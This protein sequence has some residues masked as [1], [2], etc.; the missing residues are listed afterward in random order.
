M[1]RFKSLA[2]TATPFFG[3]TLV[4]VTING[5]QIFSWTIMSMLWNFYLPSLAFAAARNFRTCFQ[6]SDTG[7][8]E[9]FSII[10]RPMLAA[11]YFSLPF[12][13]DLFHPLPLILSMICAMLG[14][15]FVA[16][17]GADVKNQEESEPQ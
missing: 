15:S 11:R 14:E 10:V 1:P 13:D 5:L 6:R 9:A 7:I 12:A 3:I 4:F 17:R 8:I 2:F 16:F